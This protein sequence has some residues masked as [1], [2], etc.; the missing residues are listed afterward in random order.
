MMTPAE[1]AIHDCYDELQ[2]HDIAEHGCSSGCATMHIYMHQ[3]WDFFLEHEDEIEDHFYFI[4]GDEWI[5]EMGFTDSSIRGLVNKIVWSYIECI[6]TKL[7][8][9]NSRNEN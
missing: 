2:L 7:T 6:A 4:F 9:V 1:K 5:N 3:T 8:E